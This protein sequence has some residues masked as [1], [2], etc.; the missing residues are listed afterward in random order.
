MNAIFS[1]G[2]ATA[3]LLYVDLFIEGVFGREPHA[4]DGWHV[5][6]E[7]AAYVQKFPQL[8]AELRKRYEAI[9]MGP[10]RAMLEHFF[11]E[12]G[13]DDDLSRCLKKYAATGQTYDGPMDRAVR[14]V[15]LRH[16]PVQDGS[17]SFY[18]HPASVAYIRKYLFGLIDGTRR[19]AALAKS[20]LI[21]IDVL[22]DE[23]GIAANNSRHP[24]VLSESPWP[25]EA[26]QP[27]A[28]AC[29]QNSHLSG[30]R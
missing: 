30:T 7:L 1:R 12:C 23:H 22:R 27:T 9:G 18:V 29:R 17:N 26:T 13:G 3:V 2:S 6:R 24:D 8:K 10:G 5:G 16:E 15:A 20:C 4:A 14:A 25:L 28:G 11:G 21:A 19:E